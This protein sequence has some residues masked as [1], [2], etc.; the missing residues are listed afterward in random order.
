VSLADRRWLRIAT[1]CV[2]YVAQGIPWG[3]MATTLPGYLLA[4]KV[5]FAFVTTTLSFTTLPYAFKWVWGPLVDRFTIARFGRR[6]PWII[7]AQGMMALTIGAMIALDVA[8]QLKLLAWMVFLHTVFNALP[9][10]AVDAL[11]VDLLSESERGSANG[12]MY[13]SKYFGGALG[14]VGM[15]KLIKSYGL[16]TALTVQCLVLLA[17]MLVPLLVRERDGAPPVVRERFRDIGAALRQAF[18]IRSSQLGVV[19]LLAMMMASGLV[20]ATGYKLFIGELKWSYDKYS[21]ITGGYALLTGCVFALSAGWLCDRF[22]RRTVA[23]TASLLLALQWIIFAFAKA[24]W[25]NH[26]YVYASGLFEATV[27][28]TLSVALITLCMDLSWPKIAATQFT[29]YMAMLNFS[30]TIGFQIADRVNKWLSYSHVFLAAA[31]LQIVATLVLI[32]IDPHETRNKLPVPAGQRVPRTG[33]VVIVGL[34][35]FLIVMTVRA[36]WDK[37]G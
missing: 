5:D 24:W 26:A 20:S 16:D 34:L 25:T 33:L 2:L 8:T 37:L 35:V 22:G 30:Q 27:Q 31:T 1:L 10:V 17:I 13:G 19:L 23:A 29:A 9:D 11:A 21:E 12:L 28:A 32:P 3:F 7:A 18:A 36:T 6:R 14:G 4:Q 15:A